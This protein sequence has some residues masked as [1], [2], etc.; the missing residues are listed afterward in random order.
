MSKK[1]MAA[2]CGVCPGGCGVEVTLE[3]GRLTDIRPQTGAPFGA[4]CMRGRHAP[5]VVYSP[6]RLKTP[7]IREGERG[8]GRFRE[9]S[10]E[11]ALDRV[12]AGMTR[13]RDRHGPEAMASHCGRGSVRAV[14]A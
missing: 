7:L 6:D 8:E 12:A 1:T 2:I 5:E 14:A 10:W 13:I 9:A 4:I 11:E 3:A